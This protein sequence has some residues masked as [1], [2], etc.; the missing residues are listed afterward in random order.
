MRI[1]F[2]QRFVVVVG[3]IKNLVSYLKRFRDISIAIRSPAPE[4][5]NKSTSTAPVFGQ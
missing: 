2:V 4:L 5:D 1:Q 3:D